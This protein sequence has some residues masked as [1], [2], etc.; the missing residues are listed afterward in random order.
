MSHRLLAALV[1]TA[2]GF[3]VGLVV[4]S[5]RARSSG[6]W[7]G[8]ICGADPTSAY[9]VPCWAH[10]HTGTG[11]KATRRVL[12]GNDQCRVCPVISDELMCVWGG[13]WCLLLFISGPLLNCDLR[14]LDLRVSG[15][16]PSAGG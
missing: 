3:C 15:P 13:S 10:R 7:G 6:L 5:S 4:L 2:D 1:F 12:H 14:D 11:R 16:A 8:I 9:C